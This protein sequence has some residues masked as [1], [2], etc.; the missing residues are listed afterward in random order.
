MGRGIHGWLDSHFHFSFAE[1]CN[2]D[3]VRFGV[4]RVLNDDV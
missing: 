3:N 2:P 1:Y 4:L